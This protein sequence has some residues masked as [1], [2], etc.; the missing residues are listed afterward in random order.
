[1]PKKVH[2]AA[3]LLWPR[4]PWLVRHAIVLAMFWHGPLAAVAI[5]RDAEGRVLF[6]RQSYRRDGR[7]GLPGGFCAHNERPS[8]AVVREVREELGLRVTGVRLLAEGAGE[9]G[10]AAFVFAAEVSGEPS[11]ATAE[12]LAWRYFGRDELPPLSPPTAELVRDA[13]CRLDETARR[14]VQVQ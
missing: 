6:V 8:R 9:F 7:W 1:M 11:I 12:L 13:L 2:R 4:L 10:E 5:I 3:L 14:V